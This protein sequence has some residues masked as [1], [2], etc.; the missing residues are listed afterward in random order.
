MATNK[1]E[2]L[3]KVNRA[4]AARIKTEEVWV[5]GA[6][7]RGW[8]VGPRF[9]TNR[10]RALRPSAASI[11]HADFYCARSRI[12]AGRSAAVEG[13][14]VGVSSTPQNL[15]KRSK[16]AMVAEGNSRTKHET[17]SV[18][19]EET[20]IVQRFSALCRGQARR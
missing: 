13:Y 5:C 2:F 11:V 1:E 8:P 10:R 17:E 15:E 3:A 18:S 14:I 9:H 20:G 16:L 12:C 7:H 4:H 19:I 6:A